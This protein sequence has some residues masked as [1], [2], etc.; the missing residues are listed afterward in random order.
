MLSIGNGMYRI[1]AD[2]VKGTIISAL[3][4]TK[5]LNKTHITNISELR[6]TVSMTVGILFK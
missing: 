4:P 1:K 6:G 2:N 3:S 5:L